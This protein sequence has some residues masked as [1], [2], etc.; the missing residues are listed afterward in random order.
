MK[1]FQIIRYLKRWMPLIVVFLI[2]MTFVTTRMLEKKQT[3]TASAVI[4]YSNTGAKD[5]EAPDGSA[6]DVT[7]IASSNNMSKA[8]ENL[9]M[10]PSSYNLDR[11]CASIR[12]EP[13]IDQQEQSIQEAK[14]E[15]GLEYTLHP[16]VYIVSCTLDSSSGGDLARGI[17]NELLDVY[18]SDYSNKHINQEQ[19]NNQTKGLIET[20]YDYLEMVEQID[21]QL[22]E[23]I[24]TLHVRYLRS[25]LFRSAATGYS[26]S[27][28]RDQ[29]QLIE[30]VDVSRLYSMI[31]GSRIS[32]DRQVLLNKYRN[33]IASLNLTG[34]NAQEDMDGITRIINAYVEKMRESGN[35]DIDHNYIL[36]DVYDRDEGLLP[37]GEPANTNRTIQYDLML[38]SWVQSADRQDYALIDAAYCA[39]IISAFENGQPGLAG[40]RRVGAAEVE[41]EIGDV[42]E[43]MNEL[44]DIVTRTN[45]EYNQYLGAHNIKM[46]SSTS[47]KERFDM[48]AY[49]MIIVVFFLVIGCCG[50]VLLG[51]LGDILEYLFLRDSATGCMN[52]VCCDK[53]IQARENL[54]LPLGASCVNIQIVNQRELN[55]A[56][57][58]EE[59]DQAFRE[60]GLVLR[61]LFEGR[62]D[63]FVG[64]NG[65]GQFWIFF[66]TTAQQPLEREVE[67]LETT[68][69]QRL[70]IPV[71]YQM[72]AVNAGESAGFYIRGLIS[73]AAKLRQP[74]QTGMASLA[75][76]A[77]EEEHE[78]D[79]ADTPAT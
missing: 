1:Q 67:R 16:T 58:R 32:K 36:N 8:M 20:D 55:E 23:T 7:E 19:V 15:E 49:Q 10:S 72:G 35:T 76:A 5:G 34:E 70:N 39:Y 30:D 22:K 52:R 44:Y 59:T 54:I 60:F 77:R 75:G 37:N 62:K 3:Y 21:A 6:I 2:G 13:L 45:T 43:R 53:F 63:S 46:L 9:G 41:Q 50:A 26:F 51:R 66:S 42:L 29:F 33:R 25:Q 78:K 27:D 56:Y 14:N 31:L 65:G 68:L 17:L 79:K 47:V 57:G 73:S 69:R 74:Y 40:G 12:V 64:Y 28:L 61:E 24:N 11:L 38:R 4:E 48:S 18:F 71:A